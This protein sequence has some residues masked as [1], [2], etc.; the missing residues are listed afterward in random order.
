LREGGSRRGRA[1]SRV[2]GLPF[3]KSRGKMGGQPLASRQR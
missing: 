1:G 2:L 3:Y